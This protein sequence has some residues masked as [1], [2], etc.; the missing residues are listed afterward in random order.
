MKM[1]KFVKSAKLKLS[2]D[3]SSK[4]MELINKHTLKNLEP[5][6]VFTFKL[7]AGDNRK[8]DR[9][10]EPFSS[11]AIDDMAKLYVGKPMIWD[12]GYGA[13]GTEQVARIYDAQSI[14][15]GNVLDDGSKEK[16]LML[17]AYML[18]TESNAGLIKE[19]EGGIKKEV[20]TSCRAKSLVCS[21]CGQD[22]MKSYCRHW[23]GRDYDGKTCLMEIKEVQDVFEVSFVGIPAQPRAGA[24]KSYNPDLPEVSPKDFKEEKP[25]SNDNQALELK[26]RELFLMREQA[27]GED[28]E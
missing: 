9:N 13:K 2:E 3:I 4:D 19:I 5:D 15:T 12:H 6:D 10:F 17:S 14:E 23:P 24:T 25:K 7:M 28:H 16:Q 27:K 21:V 11:K 18:K 8:D 26:E 1:N 20:S 22:Q